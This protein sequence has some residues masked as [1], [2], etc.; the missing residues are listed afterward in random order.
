MHNVSILSESLPSVALYLL[1][2]TKVKQSKI[3][4]NM[5]VNTALRQ[6][7][8]VTQVETRR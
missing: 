2:T 5:F 6:C 7:S 4:C 1:D 3:L 8:T